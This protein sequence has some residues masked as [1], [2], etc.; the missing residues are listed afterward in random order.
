V[1]K[2]TLACQCLKGALYWVGWVGW[3]VQG[4]VSVSDHPVLQHKDTWGPAR[5]RP[6]LST[7]DWNSYQRSWRQTYNYRTGFKNRGAATVLAYREHK[8]N[9]EDVRRMLY[10]WARETQ[11]I[12]Q[13]FECAQWRKQMKQTGRVHWWMT[14]QQPAPRAEDIVK[15][16]HAG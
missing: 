3:V 9:V 13:L 2:S 7:T 6:L 12:M 14:Q 11:F 5:Y 1:A 4:W 16:D 8:A 15:G 10:D